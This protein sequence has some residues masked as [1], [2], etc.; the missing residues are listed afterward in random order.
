MA[1]L[2]PILEELKTLKESINSD[3]IREL[4]LSNLQENRDKI[5]TKIKNIADTTKNNPVVNEYLDQI[6]KAELTNQAVSKLETNFPEHDLVKKIVEIRQSLI[7]T[8][9][10]EVS[11]EVKEASSEDVKVETKTEEIAE[12][13]SEEVAAKEA[14]TESEKA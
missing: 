10:S 1:N 14:E 9:D 12:E 3:S 11:E 5:E 4:V 2:K 8:E 7:S 13:K 6:L